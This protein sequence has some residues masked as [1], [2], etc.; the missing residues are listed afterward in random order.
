MSSSGYDKT[1]SYQV[2][3][4]VTTQRQ[5]SVSYSKTWE[6]TPFNLSTSMN[7]NQDVRTRKVNLNL[8]KVNFNVGRI[9]PLKGKT[10]GVKKWY[11]ELQFQYSASLDNQ[12][13]P[14]TTC[15]SPIRYGIRCP[16]RIH[17]R[18]D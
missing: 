12:I 2:A 4:H 11:Q 9:Y 5:S 10:P 8:P 15:C 6:G 16:E 1:N 7:H 14:M 13:A 18:P 3:D 17:M